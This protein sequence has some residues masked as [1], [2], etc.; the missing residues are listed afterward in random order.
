MGTSGSSKGSPGNVPMVPP[1]VPRVPSPAPE[2]SP[3]PESPVSTSQPARVTEPAQ[4]ARQM[5]TLPAI[6][7][8]SA[9]RFVSAR[10]SA[11]GF[12][13]SGSARDMKQSMR[14][15]VQKGYG[16]ART[17][18]R[19]LGGTVR[20]AG[21]LYTALTAPSAEAR[22]AETFIDRKLLTGRSAGKIMDAIVDAVRPVNGS[23]DA[24]AS[25][26]AIKG[27]LSEVLQRFPEADLLALTEEQREFA[28]ESYVALDVFQRFALDLGKVIQ[29]KT[30]SPRAA[31]ARLK[32]VKDYIKQT[33][34]AAFRK[35][36]DAGQA[37]SGGRLTQIVQS[38]LVDALGVF[39]HYRE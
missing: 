39:E 34:S 6:P 2:G 16:G 33:V 29:D 36:K 35:L 4:A 30:P 5:A 24:E 22:T 17:A 14:H 12:A 10:R 19:R 25:R 27:S 3:S 23:Q 11:G 21:S 7:I 28:I 37:M 31:L 20:T 15:Y 1:W 13:K 18:A 8:A 38:A 9:R 26:T 32:E